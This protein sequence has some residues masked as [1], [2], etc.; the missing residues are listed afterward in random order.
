MLHS[1]Q[2]DYEFAVVYHIF[3]PVRRL[4][5]KKGLTHCA[6][7]DHLSLTGIAGGSQDPLCRLRLIR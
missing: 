2:F 6:A 5:N 3:V 1:V 7:Q 4:P